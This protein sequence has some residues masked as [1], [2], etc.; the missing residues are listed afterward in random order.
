MEEMKKKP[1]II[2]LKVVASKI[3]KEKKLFFLVW[4]ITF[5]LSCL[6]II[7]QPRY[8]VTAVSVA[9]EIMSIGTS[10]ASIATMIASIA[11]LIK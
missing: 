4:I 8:Y 7:P 6:W 11:N 5:T 1:E 10:T 2:D 9:P 3:W